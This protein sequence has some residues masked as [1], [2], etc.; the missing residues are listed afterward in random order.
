MEWRFHICVLAAAA[1]CLGFGAAFRGQSLRETAQGA[2]ILI[3]TAVRP[4][5]LSEVAYSST[6]AREFNMLEPEDALKWEVVHPEPQSYDFSQA[7][8]M[9]DFGDS[10]RHAG[11]RSHAGLAPPEP[12]MADRRKL[13]LVRTC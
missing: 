7:D 5:Q 3:G 8:Q 2:G 9:V 10:S 6:L 4:A 11:S 13:H 1:S 12:E